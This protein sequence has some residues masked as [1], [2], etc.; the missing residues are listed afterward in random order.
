MENLQ[1]AQQCAEALPHWLWLAITF[2]VPGLA[3]H[4]DAWIR[5]PGPGSIWS[6]WPPSLK[7]SVVDGK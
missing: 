6:D 1:L 5:Q 7:T 2:A 3:A 4:L